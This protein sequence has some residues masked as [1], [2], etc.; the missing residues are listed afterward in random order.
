MATFMGRTRNLPLGKAHIAVLNSELSRESGLMGGKSKGVNPP[1]P[2]NINYGFY[3]FFFCHHLNPMTDG[4]IFNWQMNGKGFFLG[5]KGV[6]L[7]PNVSK[8]P[9]NYPHPLTNH[10]QF[11][12]I[13]TAI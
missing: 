8:P 10:T 7:F 6:L 1:P 2:H 12:P 4:K 9:T 3:F 11:R 5:R 13:A